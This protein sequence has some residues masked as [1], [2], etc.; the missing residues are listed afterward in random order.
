MNFKSFLFIAATTMFVACGESQSK[1]TSESIQAIEYKPAFSPNEVKEIVCF[2]HDLHSRDGIL[3]IISEDRWIH[4]HCTEKMQKKLI[5]E[6]DYDLEPGEI[7]YA[8]WIIGGWDPGEDGLAIYQN[9]TF[10]DEYFYVHFALNPE[11]DFYKGK[12]V[13]RYKMIYQN[14]TP[15]ID[16]CERIV[17][18]RGAEE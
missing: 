7:G 15:I 9:V 14:G 4:L 3:R 8:S 11:I 12:R 2:L 18:F 10:D 13:L 6:Y 5:D 17:D 16:D 1:M